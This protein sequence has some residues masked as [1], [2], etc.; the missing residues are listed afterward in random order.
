MHSSDGAP[1]PPG[2][3]AA[4]KP[5]PA[6]AG[7]FS[8]WMVPDGREARAPLTEGNCEAGAAVPDQAPLPAE[9]GEPP[10]G[11]AAPE[12]GGNGLCAHAAPT[13]AASTVRT[14]GTRSPRAITT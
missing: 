3:A 11:W 2:A 14:I 6:G 7:S 4:P 13:G 1:P 8:G 5:G 10:L 9:K 12:T